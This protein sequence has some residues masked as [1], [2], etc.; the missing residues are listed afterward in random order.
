[1]SLNDGPPKYRIVYN[2]D[3]IGPLQKARYSRTGPVT[4]EDYVEAT[5]GPLRG[6]P[7]DAYLWCPGHDLTLVHDTKSGEFYGHNVSTFGD[8]FMAAYHDTP[9]EL[10]EAGHDPLRLV[11]DA[12]HDADMDVFAT[13]RMNDLHAMKPD[14]GEALSEFKK[15]HPEYLVR[16]PRVSVSPGTYERAEQFALNHIFSEVRKVR[17][18]MIAELAENY[19]IDGIDMDFMR[20][21]VYFPQPESYAQRHTLTEFVGRIRESLNSIGAAR[22]RKL[23]LTARVPDTLEAGLRSGLDVRRWLRQ[24]FLDSVAIGGGYYEFGSPFS[25]MST[26]AHDFGVPAYA[27]LSTSNSQ[28]AHD[29]SKMRGAAFRAWTSGVDGLYLFNYMYPPERPGGPPSDDWF[30][31]LDDIG[32]PKRLAVQSRTYALDRSMLATEPEVAVYYAHAVWQG[33]VP[34]S[35]G[36]SSDEIGQ[37]VVF[38]IPE[39]LKRNHPAAVALWLKVEQAYP[40]DD[41]AISWNGRMLPWEDGAELRMSGRVMDNYWEF[42]F[43]LDAGQIVKGENALRIVLS[44]RAEHLLPF[45][46][47]RDAEVQIRY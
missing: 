26:V 42:T 24:G 33:Q 11:A 30:K 47:L 25:E 12:A 37:T 3:G 19:P 29:Q 13:V 2:D 23:M 16:D 6:T 1:M 27:C 14:M 39:D 4:A 44:K 38:D 7:V 46:I 40:G 32:D 9:R 22:G 10:I 5:I 35:V 18:N 36:M 15:E 28:Y 20:F 21:P 8:T 34:L 31:L 45:V 17:L 41:L 43:N